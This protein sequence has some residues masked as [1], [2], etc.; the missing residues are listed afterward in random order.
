MT[1][2]GHDK[3]AVISGQLLLLLAEDAGEA[4]LGGD[5]HRPVRTQTNRE[6]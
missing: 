6:G 5:G 2:A 4:G 3:G 1:I